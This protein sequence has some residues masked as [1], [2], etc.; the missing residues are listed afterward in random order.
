MQLYCD[1][2]MPS[3]PGRAKRKSVFE[4]AQN[5]WIQIILRMHKVSYGHLLSIHNILS[6]PMIL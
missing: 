4:N 2:Y 3:R 1:L 6:Y 5:V